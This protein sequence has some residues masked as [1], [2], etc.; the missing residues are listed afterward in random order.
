[1]DI[2]QE[3][4][5]IQARNRK[6]EADKAWEVSWTR[7][8]FIT[9]VTYIFALVWLIIIHERVAALKALVPTV[10]FVLSTLSLGVIKGW[11]VRRRG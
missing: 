2:E 11:W 7:R 6:V 4:E 8:L 1:M 9:A 3:L 10:G 5:K